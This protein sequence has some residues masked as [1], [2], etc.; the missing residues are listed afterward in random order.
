MFASKSK[1]LQ[2]V[3]F[4]LIMNLMYICNFDISFYLSNQRDA[5]CQD[6]QLKDGTCERK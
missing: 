2:W 5:C 4:C 3:V 6:F 1:M